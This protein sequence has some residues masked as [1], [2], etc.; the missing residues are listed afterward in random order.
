MW[1]THFGFVGEARVKGRKL[2]HFLEPFYADVLMGEVK[3]LYSAAKDGRGKPRTV[4]GKK[5]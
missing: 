2:D 5:I 4:M 3:V 1:L